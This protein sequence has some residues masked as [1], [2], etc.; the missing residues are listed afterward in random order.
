MIN[1]KFMPKIGENRE[2]IAKRIN[3][4]KKWSRD[5]YKH[6][7]PLRATGQALNIAIALNEIAL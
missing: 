3:S 2:R 1:N 5:Q 6:E 4:L 7:R